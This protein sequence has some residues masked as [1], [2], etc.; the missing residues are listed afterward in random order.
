MILQRLNMDNSWFLELSG[1]RLLIDPWL[2]G[3]EVDYFSWFNT[4]WHRTPPISYCDVPDF[5]AVL[6]TQKYPDH[7]HADTLR[8]LQPS[9]VLAPVSI[10]RRLERLLPNAT[11][12][13]F[14]LGCQS[15]EVGQLTVT[16]LPTR[17]R[18]DP[19]YDA[20]LL[21]DGAE[22]LLMANHGLD[23]DEQHR[24]QMSDCKTVDVLIS[25][26]NRYTLPRFLGGVVTPGIEGLDALVKQ[27]QPRT[28]VQTHDEPKHGSGLIPALARIERFSE[29]MLLEHPWLQQKLLNITDYAPVQP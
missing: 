23:F 8:R 26:L 2:E 24:E 15:H 19:I 5:D 20:F 3:A 21:T 10:A 25:P 17:R 9:L 4:Q 28:I 11:L 16:Q 12:C 27:V 7:F 22:S 18:I 29:D 13:L 1:S 14:E 6:L